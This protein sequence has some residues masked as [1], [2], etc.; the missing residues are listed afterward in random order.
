M[1]SEKEI[2]EEIITRL[3]EQP[4]REYRHGAWENFKNQNLS[5]PRSM[6][7]TRWVSAAAALLLLGVGALYYINKDSLSP[8]ATD[9]HIASRNPMLNTETPHLNEHSVG[10]KSTSTNSSVLTEPIPHMSIL[11]ETEKEGRILSANQSGLEELLNL[12]L[13]SEALSDVS[14]RIDLPSARLIKET[15][16]IRKYSSVGVKHPQ[17]PVSIPTDL[18]LAS[19]A[20]PTSAIN[21]HEVEMV[22]QNKQVRFGDKFDL[23]LFV[24]PYSTGDKMNVGGGLTLAYNLTKNI[25]IRTGASYNSYEVGMLKNPT[26]SSSSEAV[27][28]TN[29]ADASRNM[30]SFAPAESK[31]II[32]NVNA[33]TS[34]VQSVDIPI[35]LK[36][37]VGKSLYAVA[38]VSYSAIV[39]QERNAHYVDNINTETFSQGAPENEK[40][41]QTAVKAISK[42]VKSAE[43]NVST[44]GFNGFVNFSIGRKVKL[45]NKFGVSIE[46][47][48][49]IPV[50]EYRRADMDYTNG[51][52]RIMTNF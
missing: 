42:T 43:E 18:I 7:M 52:I 15:I 31:M 39:G 37:N 26:E 48:L 11:P 22:S 23:G 34:I 9:I 35:E 14:S 2:I 45:N 41:M 49:K 4:D 38:G 29:N 13:S 47:Y 5:T 17:A 30:A 20:I 40:Q 51:G 46:P 27:V 50:G 19:K 3:K 1:K 32:P 24:S 28:V 12:S 16:S 25:S 10:E 6:Q 33:V 44:K 36:Y 21:M 8:Q